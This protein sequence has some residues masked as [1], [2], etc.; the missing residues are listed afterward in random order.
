MTTISDLN[1]KSLVWKQPSAWH[2]AYV[3]QSSTGELGRLCF[4]SV[5]KEI[6]EIEFGSQAWTFDRRGFFGRKVLIWRR[7]EAEPFGEY[8]PET[9]RRG[10]KLDMG[11][12]HGFQFSTNFWITRLDI[13][14]EQGELLVSLHKDGIFR[15]SVAVELQPEANELAEIPLLISLGLYML[16]LIQHDSATQASVMGANY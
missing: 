16:L 13:L 1:L 14:D 7:G 8:H 11:D 4:P 15:I 6:A 12:G 9:F 10:G 3:L 2:R 5:W